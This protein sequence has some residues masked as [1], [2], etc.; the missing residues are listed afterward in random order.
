M[1]TIPA[2]QVELLS[3]TPGRLAEGADPV[4]IVTIRE[5]LPSFM[6]TDIVL[7]LEHAEKLFESLRDILPDLRARY[8]PKQRPEGRTLK[9]FMDDRRQKP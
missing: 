3:V 6:P 7:S 2:R 9:D 8:I 4:A 1:N 5:N